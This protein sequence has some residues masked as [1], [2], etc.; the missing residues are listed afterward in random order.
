MS[1]I[2]LKDIMPVMQDTDD[3]IV[4]IKQESDKYPQREAMTAR[5]ALADFSERIV[6]EVAPFIHEDGEYAG[7]IYTLRAEEG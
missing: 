3:T 6:S 7:N 2:K 5:D 1:G 4:F